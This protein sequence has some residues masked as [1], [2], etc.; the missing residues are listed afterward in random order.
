VVT[1]DYRAAGERSTCCGPL[2]RPALLM[3]W[4]TLTFNRMADAS[5]SFS[6]VHPVSVPIQDCQIEA[7]AQKFVMLR[8]KVFLDRLQVPREG[9]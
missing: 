2:S 3:C 8:G 1:R 9:L 6:W 5:S 4:S 7:I